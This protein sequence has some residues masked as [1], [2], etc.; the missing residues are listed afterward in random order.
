[1]RLEQVANV[2]DSVEDETNG[3]WFFSR[4]ARQPRDQPGGEAAAR[5]QHHRS[6]RRVKAAARR[7]VPQLPPS[8]H[9]VLRSDRSK[10]IR[11]AFK[12]IQFTMV[13]TLALVIGVI[14][15]FLRNGSATLIPALA[16]PFSILGTFAVM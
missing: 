6:H 3:S 2:I 5:Q 9:M 16:L 7:S 10:T 12:D 1:M 8:V 15:L 11:E 14:F 13:I 4:A